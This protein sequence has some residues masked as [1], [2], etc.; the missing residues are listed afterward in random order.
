MHILR[1]NEARGSKENDKH[2]TDDSVL[3]LTVDVQAVLLSPMLNASSLYYKTKLAVH[4]YTI[5][6]LKNNNVRC[7]LWNESQGGL[8]S[9]CFATMLIDYLTD[10]IKKDNSLIKSI[11]VYSDGCTYQNRCKVLSN[12]LMY[13][14]QKNKILVEQY[15]LERGHT[16]MEVDSVHAAIECKLKK[17][18]VYV[19]ADYE[20]FIIKARTDVPYVVKNLQW[21]FFLDYSKL[22]FYDSIKPI[23]GKVVDIRCLKYIPNKGIQYKK[24]FTSSWIDLEEE[25][26]KV[27][28][29]ENPTQLYTGPIAIKYSKYQHLQQLK[30]VMPKKYWHFYDSLIHDE[31][32]KSLVVK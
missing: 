16:Q 2:L 6:N 14:A 10:E 13:F 15:F 5:Y 23:D 20:H 3:V 17:Q 24:L 27:N 12:A 1:K 28:V 8:T 22:N 25:I 4:N 19:P 18:S 21:D 9:N 31:P 30:Q 29:N 7:Y 11:K 26:K 32:S